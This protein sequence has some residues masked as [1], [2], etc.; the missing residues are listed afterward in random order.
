MHP[1]VICLIYCEYYKF[2]NDCLLRTRGGGVQQRDL[3]APDPRLAF[4]VCWREGRLN[5]CSARTHMQQQGATSPAHHFT[6][7]A[8]APSGGGGG[9]GRPITPSQLSPK[10]LPQAAGQPPSPTPR[11]M[12]SGPSTNPPPQHPMPPSPGPGPGPHLHIHPANPQPGA[13]QTQCPAPG[14]GPG[15]GSGPYLSYQRPYQAD[16]AVD[17]QLNV[18]RLFIAQGHFSVSRYSGSFGVRHAHA[19]LRA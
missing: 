10:A 5:H 2:R 18:C 13:M 12:A 11:P 7:Q 19:R 17:H 1:P 14:S 9:V 8:Q 6:F 4:C 3:H 15:S 16:V